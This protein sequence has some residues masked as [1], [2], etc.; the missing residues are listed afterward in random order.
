MCLLDKENKYLYKHFKSSREKV[1]RWKLVYK[2]SIL[3]GKYV[4]K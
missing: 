3:V 2:D 1:M 4:K